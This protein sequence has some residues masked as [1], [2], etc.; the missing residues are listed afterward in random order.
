M[1][2]NSI[3][4]IVI[5]IDKATVADMPQVSFHGEITVVDT[6]EKALTAVEELSKAT[7]VGFDTE[8]R[9]AFRRG[10]VNRVALM[11]ISTDDHCFLFRVNRI[12]ITG[13]LR[14][15]IENAGIVKVGLSLRDDFTVMHRSDD[16]I[17]ASFIDLQK[18]VG[19]YHIAELGLQR[20]YAILFGQRISKHQ[21][22]TNWE[23]G[24]LT[25]AQQT[26]AAIDAWACLR[27]Y[28]YLKSGKFD[29]Y[30]CRYIRVPD[31]AVADGEKQCYE[32]K[33][34]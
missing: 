7:I 31:D 4:D 24:I 13:A 20:I 26:Y 8:T 29:P 21:R 30:S 22:L 9:P 27:I 15:F 33:T 17:P 3:S 6:E 19:D 32:S 28:N 11:Q 10:Q 34:L 12:G 1:E 16:F 25:P 18:V 5:G 14:G 2:T 23:A